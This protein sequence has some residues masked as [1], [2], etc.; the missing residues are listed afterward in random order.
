[1]L[2]NKETNTKITTDAEKSTAN[3][4]DIELMDEPHTSSEEDAP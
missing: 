1:M 4:P 2:R 3:T